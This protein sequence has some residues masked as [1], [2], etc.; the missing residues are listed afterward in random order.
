MSLN[1]Y[2]NEILQTVEL[3]RADVKELQRE[4]RELKDML[5]H[6]H[7]RWW[8]AELQKADEL[9]AVDELIKSSNQPDYL[10]Y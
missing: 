2:I 4:N 10:Q 9:K 5:T 6:T 3:L 1:K 7:H 8:T